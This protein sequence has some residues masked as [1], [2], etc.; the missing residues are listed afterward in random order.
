VVIAYV[1]VT[2]RMGWEAAFNFVRD[3][4]PIVCPNIGFRAQLQAWELR[5]CLSGDT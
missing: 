3:R 5:K 1:M 4:R 2:R